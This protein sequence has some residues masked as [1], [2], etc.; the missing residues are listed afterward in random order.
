M[1]L[2]LIILFVVISN[3]LLG[4]ER[5]P[6]LIGIQP[7]ITKETFY[8][9]NEFDI[10][11]VPLMV[12]TPLTKKVDL[13]ATVIANYR[14]GSNS[15]FSDLGIEFVLPYHFSKQDRL[16]RSSGFYAGPVANLG[17]NIIADHYTVTLA[18]E[19]GYLFK[20]E[21][22]FTLALG[23]QIGSSFFGY[24]DLPNKWRSHF[25]TKVNLGFWV[26]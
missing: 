15:G 26:R 24:D 10:N 19:P 23:M 22:N 4:Q 8:D 1:K 2:R 14:S 3:T 13:R 16:N 17:R 11:V 25:G 21:K 9:T 6:L 12:Q 20:A 5:A 18:L 7:G